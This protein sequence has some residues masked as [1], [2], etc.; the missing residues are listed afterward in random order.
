MSYILPPKIE[1]EKSDP[2]TLFY[3]ITAISVSIFLLLFLVQK[4]ANYFTNNNSNDNGSVLGVK[5]DNQSRIN[6]LKNKLV[7][8]PVTVPGTPKPIINAKNYVLV[9]QKSAEIIVAKDEHIS[10]PI[11]S[12]TKLMTA[13]LTMENGKLDAITTVSK[14]AIYTNGSTIGLAINEKISINDLLNALLINSANDSAI[15][16]AEYIS[17]SEEKFVE[18]MNSKANDLR[19]SNTRFLD[20]A[21]LNDEGR[22]SANDIAILLSYALRFD[23]IKSIIKTPEKDI[24]SI[25]GLTHHLVNSNRLVKEEMFFSGIIGGK[26]GFTPTAGHNLVSAAERDGHILI[27]VIINTYSSSITAS[28]EECKSLLEWGFNNLKYFY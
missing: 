1:K 27:A 6:E 16:L 10:V 20:P 9:D 11:A 15:V 12:I 4:S 3:K 13:I 28:A 17:G 23:N 26:T 18:L 25:S 21:G 8:P 19:M 22:S 2:K 14:N 24:V 5:N 7:L